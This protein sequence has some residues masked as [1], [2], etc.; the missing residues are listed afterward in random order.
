MKKTIIF[1]YIIVSISIIVFGCFNYSK[2]KEMMI[3]EINKNLSSTAAMIASE[4]EESP[5]I[6]KLSKI[7][8]NPSEF[9]S[10]SIEYQDLIFMLRKKHK[11]IKD[12]F[13]YVY[14]LFQ[15]EESIIFGLDTAEPIY[16][17][18]NGKLDQAQW[19]EKYETPPPALI[20]SFKEK[21]QVITQE[22]YTD[23]WGLFIQY[24]IL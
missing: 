3:G 24:I 20:K 19:N 8:N 11:P 22:P 6:E 12:D 5:Y 10:N 23:V 7:V 4:L 17:S 9:N 13:I 21:N 14:T 1:L 15:K 18:Q 16:N 2:T